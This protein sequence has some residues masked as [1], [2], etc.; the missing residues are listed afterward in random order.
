MTPDA[1]AAKLRSE[2]DKPEHAGKGVTNFYWYM[3]FR[4][5]GAKIRTL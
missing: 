1:V 4:Y 2:Y 5:L 3:K